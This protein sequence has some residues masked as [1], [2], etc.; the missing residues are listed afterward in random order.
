MAHSVGIATPIA[1][2][3]RR[4][5]S[6]VFTAFC[7]GALALSVASVL[8]PARP[9]AGIVAAVLATVPEWLEI[10]FERRCARR[11]FVPDPLAPDFTVFA[12]AFLD[13]AA[14][15]G[16]GDAPLEWTLCPY[17]D[18]NGDFAPYVIDLRPA[19]GEVAFGPRF[20]ELCVKTDIL[21]RPRIALPIEVRDA[22]V[23]LAIS[24]SGV[25][26]Q[27]LI[28]AGR[29]FVFPW[30]RRGGN[31]LRDD[32]AKL[33]PALACAI[34]TAFPSSAWAMPERTLAI[35]LLLVFATFTCARRRT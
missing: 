3:L 15:C 9:W 17:C 20:H 1:R 6:P 14:E 4:R 8:F 13:S 22:P 29:R 33:W 27:V 7:D 16:A 32:L 21:F 12:L 19:K 28:S 24:P 2:F 18:A 34:M 23:T 5:P 10:A 35:A 11:V 25:R 31:W 26:R 30:N